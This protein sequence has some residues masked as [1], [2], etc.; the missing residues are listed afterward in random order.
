MLQNNSIR[1]NDRRKLLKN[2]IIVKT[3]SWDP[4]RRILQ[5]SLCEKVCWISNQIH[6]LYYFIR[7]VLCHFFMFFSLF[8]SA[9]RDLDK[10]D[11][12]KSRSKKKQEKVR[13]M[14]FLSV[15]YAANCGGTGTLT[16][17]G[18][19]SPCRLIYILFRSTFE[20]GPS[21]VWTSQDLAWPDLRINKSN[22]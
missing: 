3:K 18:K 4:C 9:W 13:H 10:N 21:K 5:T 22:E 11:G 15:A 7:K 20:N 8:F 14:I 17:T 2:I 19:P 12:R 1:M 6:T 16:G